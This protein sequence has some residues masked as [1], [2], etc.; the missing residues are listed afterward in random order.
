MFLIPS[1]TQVYIQI[2]TVRQFVSLKFLYEATW[3]FGEKFWPNLRDTGYIFSY[4]PTYIYEHPMLPILKK[5]ER[6]L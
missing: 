5:D 4:V 3:T 2:M 6:L 1:Y